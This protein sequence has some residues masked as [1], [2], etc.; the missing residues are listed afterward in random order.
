MARLLT[1]KLL[2]CAPCPH[3]HSY[4]ADRFFCRLH[5]EHFADIRGNQD[6]HLIPDI[7]GDIPEWCEL[8]EV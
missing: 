4:S 5:T 1:I 6:Y 3:C 8:E 7:H 2:T